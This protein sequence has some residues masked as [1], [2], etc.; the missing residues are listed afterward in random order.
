[1]T[2]GRLIT[3]GGM[4]AGR[5][6]V[7]P[8]R[9][10]LLA[11]LLPP[12]GIAIAVAL[13]GGGFTLLVRRLSGGFAVA[14]SPVLTWG[15]VVAGLALVTA[16]D[17]LTGQGDW[18]AGL[19]ARGGLL[20]AAAATLPLGGGLATV[21]GLVALAT[22]A[23][24]AIGPLLPPALDLGRWRPLPARGPLR[25]AAEP[26]VEP[27]EPAPHP[28]DHRPVPPSDGLRQRVERF[29][30]AAGDD[31]L[32]G[33]LLVAVAA[34]S[35]LGHAHVGFCPP[36][37]VTPAVDV[38][39]DCDFVETELSAAEVLP[40]GVRVE[41]RL[42]EQADEP[43]EIPVDIVVRTTALPVPRES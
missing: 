42:S 21:L 10:D 39:T 12:A 34:G 40:W 20:A 17:R 35:R 31:C 38:T 22:G 13:A 4:V 33:H 11:A 32:R 37:A 1:M 18:R 8:G 43:L 19:P 3:D 7:D 15:V 41:C 16:S 25:P 30:T 26:V 28:A 24:A 14:P 27:P 9:G 5:P 2:A 29:V 6:A 23:A 36:F